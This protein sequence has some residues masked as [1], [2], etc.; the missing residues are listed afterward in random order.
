MRLGVEQITNF[1]LMILYYIWIIVLR[2]YCIFAME[3]HKLTLRVASK[4]KIYF[5]RKRTYP[6]IKEER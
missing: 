2:Q 4:L 5:G 3:H 6:K 1:I